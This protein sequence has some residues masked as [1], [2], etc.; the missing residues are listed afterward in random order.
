MPLVHGQNISANEIEAEVSRWDPVPFAR[1]CNAIAW[2]AAWQDT[3]SVPAFTERVTIADNGID[4]QWTG[5]ITL[6]AGQPSLLRTGKN[7]FQYKKREITEQS[8]SRIVAVLVA[9]RHGEAR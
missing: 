7:V 3:P 9:D 2:A 6:G 8:R 1:L 5:T 4:A